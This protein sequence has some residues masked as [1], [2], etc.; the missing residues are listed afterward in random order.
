MVI[1]RL[2]AIWDFGRPNGDPTSAENVQNLLELKSRQLHEL[3]VM[4]TFLA[5]FVFAAQDLYR[6]TYEQLIFSMMMVPI[7]G[8]NYWLFRKGHILTS[9]VLNH[10][11]I[12]ILPGV[13]Q[14]MI[15]PQVGLVAFYFPIMISAL[16]TFQG[17]ERIFGY[18]IV[19][20]SLWI[21]ALLVFS[22]LRIGSLDFSEP[23]LFKERTFNVFAAAAITLMEFIYLLV[24]SN[25]I[26]SRLLRSHQEVD[27]KVSELSAVNQELDFKNDQLVKANSELDNV[28]Y[29]VSHDLRAP[30]LSVKGLLGLLERLPDRRPEAIEYTSRAMRSVVR[31]DETIS[32]ILV[33]SRNS[34]KEI[35]PEE[36]SLKELIQEIFE[37]LRFVASPDHKFMTSLSGDDRIFYDRY[38][39]NIILKNLISNSVK[40]ARKDIPDPFVS[41][42]IANT[43]G[44]AP[45]DA[46][47]RINVSDNGQGISP[48]HQPRVF[49]MFYRAT[50][51]SVGTGLG[52]YICSEMV[53][54][55]GGV[56]SL[57]SELNRG[58]TTAIDLP[59]LR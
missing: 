12:L 15:L 55:L 44:A 56:I 27:R 21:T 33:F 34:R 22:D 6:G 43:L 36:F 48:E 41:V 53:K 13:V 30:L 54:K 35:E 16:I 24:L 26:Q 38:R 5:G 49:E 47:L 4:T 10:L 17:K 46:G 8:L 2:R 20:L 40:Y 19:L 51:E 59:Q 39:L 57:N 31:L 52:L 50:S 42:D 58:T 25:N 29:R 45:P 23:E 1:D 9:K 14:L 28:V 11:Q 18:W 7:S 3:L 37:D 32:E